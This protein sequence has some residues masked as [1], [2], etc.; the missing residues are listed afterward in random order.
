M[1]FLMIIYSI[2]KATNKLLP[3]KHY[4]GYTENFG[5]RQ[6]DHFKYSFH[7][8]MSE[9]REYNSEFHKALREFGWDN[10]EWEIVY[11]SLD[12][13]HT[14]KKMEKHFIV[15]YKSHFKKG[16]GYNMTYGGQGTPG[17]KWS[18]ES[19]I[20]KNT[21]IKKMIQEGTW[22]SPFSD[23]EIHKKSIETRTIRGTNVYTTNNPMHNP[24]SIAKKVEK[25]SGLN[26]YVIK[27]YD[28]WYEDIENNIFP[29][30]IEKTLN[31]SLLELGI[32]G[33][34]YRKFCNT[35]LPITKGLLKGMRIFKKK[36]IEN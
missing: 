24:E 11:Q 3:Y 13:I 4:I 20:V 19:L 7:E 8:K 16:I 26:H 5:K 9:K 25:T 31:D 34:I 21:V 28:Y 14:L 33:R 32:D 23:P 29:I 12:M 30:V 10:F 35:N 18:K 17:Y 1:K 36:K 22:I 2:Y 15:E 6:Y 27:N